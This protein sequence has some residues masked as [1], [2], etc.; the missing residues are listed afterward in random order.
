VVC[1]C[2]CVQRTYYGGII[3]AQRF[4]LPLAKTLYL[5]VGVC[6]ARARQV[7]ASNMA[8][9]V[10][11]QLA[12]LSELGPERPKGSNVSLTAACRHSS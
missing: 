12:V 5:P 6:S 4:R 9:G 8:P 11:Q 10:R 2:V 3:F 1:V 7:M